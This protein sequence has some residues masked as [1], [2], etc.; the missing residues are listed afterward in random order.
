VIV[1]LNKKTTHVGLLSYSLRR[2]FRGLDSGF[3]KTRS[4]KLYS[5]ER[6]QN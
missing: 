1:R 3:E 2:Q 4:M 6:T 5:G